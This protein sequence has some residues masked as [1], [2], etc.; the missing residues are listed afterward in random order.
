MKSLGIKGEEIAAAYL[1]N[2]GYNI[3]KR[4]Y[5]VP[6]GEA[7]IIAKDKDTVVFVEVK[8]RTNKSFGHPFEA[9][10]FRKQERLKRIALFYIKSIKTNFKVRFDV[11]SITSEAGEHKINHIK[12]AF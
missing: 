2:E 11:I 7:D 4:N 9:V 12:E 3:L 1:K 5:K 8:T 10:D 6:Y